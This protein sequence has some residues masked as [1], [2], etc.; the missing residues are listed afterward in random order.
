M[1]LFGLI[2]TFHSITLSQT[3]RYENHFNTNIRFSIHDN[4]IYQRPR[5][6]P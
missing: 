1:E 4:I 2:L 6:P 5:Q 3:Q